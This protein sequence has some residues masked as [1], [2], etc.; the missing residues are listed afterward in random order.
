MANET[1][2]SQQKNSLY[3]IEFYTKHG[4]INFA[5]VFAISSFD[6]KYKLESFSRF[7]EVIQVTEQAEIVP[8]SGTTGINT[9]DANVFIL[10]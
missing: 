10:S 7:D 5:W 6:A 4:A 2:M 9:P 1:A 3:L 8:L